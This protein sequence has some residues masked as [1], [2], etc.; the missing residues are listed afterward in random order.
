VEGG[1]PCEKCGAEKVRCSGRLRCKPCH[2]AWGAKYR[3]A[4]PEKVKARKAKYH[5]ANSEKEKAR[6][7]KYHAANPEKVKARLAEYRAA[8]PEKVKA[9]KAEYRAAN[10]EKVKARKA[11]YRAANPEKGMLRSARG[12]AREK[13][14]DFNL[15]LSDI[16]IPAKCPV[17]GIPLVSGSGK[18]SP[19][20]NSPSLDRIDSRK[21]YVKGNIW[22]ISWQANRI[23]SDSTPEELIAIGK[24]VERRLFPRLVDKLMAKS[25]AAAYIEAED[26]GE[27]AE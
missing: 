25:K 21:G 9:R 15:E 3:A 19:Q 10:P 8:N 17:L 6:L 4:N 16:I 18:G 12:R 13:G 1:K 11:E 22:V 7:A 14:W 20:R 26:E 23:K 5:A 2:A 27:A 24:A